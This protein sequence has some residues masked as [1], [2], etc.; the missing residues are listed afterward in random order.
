MMRWR[1]K[2]TGYD[3]E[4]NGPTPK[5]NH[6]SQYSI[7]TWKRHMSRG[8][9]VGILFIDFSKAFNCVDHEIMNQ[10]LIG[11]GIAGQL[12]KVI[13]SYLENRQK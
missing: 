3:I 4:T 2:L 6:Q 1:N 5:A 10:K 8:G 12:Y 9:V 13:E 11:A 7:K